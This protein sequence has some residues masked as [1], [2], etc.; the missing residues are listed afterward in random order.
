MTAGAHLRE[1]GDALDRLEA[2]P[3]YPGAGR[4]EAAEEV[5]RLVGSIPVLAA[6]LAGLRTLAAREL[7][8][9]G[10]TTTAIA[11]LAGVTR[12][13]IA[14]LLIAEEVPA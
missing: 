9:A 7:R 5:L 14:Q 4:Q 12:S 6:E 8:S 1:L 11:E 3:N 2:P 13:A 10:L